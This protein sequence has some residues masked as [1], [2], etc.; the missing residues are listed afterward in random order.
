MGDIQRII[1]SV[2]PEEFTPKFDQTALIDV[3]SQ[4]TKGTFARVSPVE[5]QGE[6][7]VH[8]SLAE[9]KDDNIKEM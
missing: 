8:H 2:L 6:S 4:L 7:P 1:K 5:D 3:I 9:E